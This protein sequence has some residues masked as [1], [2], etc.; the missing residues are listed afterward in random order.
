MGC[1]G[2]SLSGG[3]VPGGDPAWA[4][5]TNL[6]PHGDGLRDWTYGDF[7]TL[8]T[9]G[10]RRDGSQVGEPM[11]TFSAYGRAMTETELHAL[12]AY[13]RSIPPLPTAD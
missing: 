12:W 7:V 2:V 10:R 13:L 11:S 5:A 9:E 8:L 1:H 3:P 4:P 6:T